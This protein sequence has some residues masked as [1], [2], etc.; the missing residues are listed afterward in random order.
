MELLMTID[1]EQRKINK[2]NR[3]I[4]R[5]N[6]TEKKAEECSNKG[7]NMI[8]NIPLGQPIHVGHY[9]ENSDRNFRNKADNYIRKSI[10][11]HNKA[12]EYKDKAIAKINNHDISSDDPNVITKLKDK[13]QELESKRETM[14]SL[15]KAWNVFVKK[16]NRND[17]Y[18]LGLCDESIDKM[19]SEYDSNPCVW[20]RIPYPKYE[21][22]NIAQTILYYKKRLQ[23]EI[24][25]ADYISDSNNVFHIKSIDCYAIDNIEE[26]RTQIIFKT[27]PQEEII[28]ELKRS[29]FKWSNRNRAWQRYISNQ[30]HYHAQRILDIYKEK[31]V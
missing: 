22:Q 14:K 13:V 7:W 20:E 17:L 28:I 12:V 27:K 6:S 10:E 24:K 11:L 16:G 1:Y 30:A 2:I 8:S 4:E 29:G 9:S 3:L 25:K 18:N 15:N 26:N 5:S 21:T 19:K 31:L 23:R